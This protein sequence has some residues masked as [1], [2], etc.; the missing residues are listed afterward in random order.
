MGQLGGVE[1]GVDAVGDP[2]GVEHVGIPQAGV[3]FVVEGDA[4]AVEV[5]GEGVLGAAIGFAIV[6]GKTGDIAQ[7]KCSCPPSSQA[8]FDG[9]PAFGEGVAQ[10]L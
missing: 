6:F 8:V 9:H 2:V 10:M 3:V 4:E 1:Q 5:D 7:R